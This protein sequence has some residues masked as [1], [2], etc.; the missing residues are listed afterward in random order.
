MPTSASSRTFD[1]K[2]GCL[3]HYHGT[4]WRR[5]QIK[6]SE[7]HGRLIWIRELTLLVVGCLQLETEFPN[8]HTLQCQP[9]PLRPWLAPHRYIQT[10]LRLHIQVGLLTPFRDLQDLFL[11]QSRGGLQITKRSHLLQS[12]LDHN[13]NRCRRSR[14]RLVLVLV[15]APTP[16]S[17]QSLPP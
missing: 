12:R 15:L 17:L 9:W 6:V 7:Y 10:P 11:L 5:K 2:E 8:E 14:R 16:M 3:K 4:I 1:R 13:D